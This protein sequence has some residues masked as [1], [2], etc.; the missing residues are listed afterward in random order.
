MEQR[1]D[2]PPEG[3]GGRIGGVSRPE[4]IL[5]VALLAMAALIP[6]IQVGARVLSRQG[7]PGAGEYLQHIVLWIAF[8]CGAI[9]STQGRHLAFTIGYQRISGRA[10]TWSG[11]F[12]A[13]VSAFFCTMLSIAGLSFALQGFE[14]GAAAGGIPLLILAMIIPAG[15][16]LMAARFVLRCPASPKARWAAALGIPAG[17]LFSTEPLAGIL[18]FVCS[19]CRERFL[20]CL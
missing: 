15:F 17:F 6:F 7:I 1:I 14:P 3:A 10:K 18:E 8:T 4:A 5:C 12:T 13:A 20:C 9:T 16:A 11:I 2:T 19:S